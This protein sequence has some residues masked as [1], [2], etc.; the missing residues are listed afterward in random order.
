MEK[1]LEYYYDDGT[2]VKFEK[3]TIDMSGVVRNKKT[4]ISLRSSK[5]K[6]GYNSCGVI[7]NFGKHRHVLVGRAIA[8][9]FIGIPPSLSHTTDHKDRDPTNDTLG[10]IQWLCKPGQS[11]NQDR[12]EDYKSASFVV[13]DG[14]EKTIKEWFDHL[15]GEKNTYGRSYT[16]AIITQY[17]QKKQHGFSY[18]EYI[19]LPGEV[20]KEI[21][22]SKTLAGHWEI[23]NMNRVKYIT[24]YAE[25]ILSDERIGLMLGYPVI[26]I[27]GR[28]WRCHILSFMTFFPDEY[29]AKKHGEMVLHEDDDPMDFRP[30]KLRLGTHSHNGIDAHNN[31]KYD[32]T[33]RERVK[34]ISYID[35]V[36]EK[37]HESQADAM[38]YLIYLGYKKASYKCISKALNKKN[39]DGNSKTMYGRAWKMST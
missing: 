32:G 35:G 23:S 4:G 30:H 31:G 38:R 29:A 18:K 17:A 8:S 3:Y 11:A 24:K 34:C 27:K 39:K 7:D 2:H 33:L 10:N 1:T 9:T 37:E 22:G 16:K 21:I 36:F 26:K 25:N 15:I 19:N 12:P 6:A 5:N 28:H 13:K 14:V 20:W